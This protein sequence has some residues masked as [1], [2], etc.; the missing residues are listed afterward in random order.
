[1]NKSQEEDRPYIFSG[2]PEY[3]EENKY[4]GHGRESSSRL[5]DKRRQQSVNPFDVLVDFEEEKVPGRRNE[6]SDSKYNNSM[7]EEIKERLE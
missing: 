3:D 2:T 5:L 7:D 1:M 6:S 4:E